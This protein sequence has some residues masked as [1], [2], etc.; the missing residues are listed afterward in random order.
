MRQEE[1]EVEKGKKSIKI[2]IRQY[3][4]IFAMLAIWAYFQ[5]ATGGIFMMPRNLNNLFLQMCYIGV[6]SC[7]MVLIMVSGQ[8]D[9]SAGSVIG[10]T[11][12]I[13]AVLLK[14]FNMN[15][16]LALVLTLAAG[17]L[18]GLW[19]GIWVA[20]VGLPAF[21]VTLS[22]MMLFRGGVLGVTGGSTVQPNDPVFKAIGQGYIPNIGSG[23]INITAIIIGIICFAIYVV[24]MLQKRKNRMKYQFKVDKA[25]V[26]VAK[27][28]GFGIVMGLVFA[29]WASDRGIPIPIIILALVVLT[30]HVISQNT[31][32]G[33]HIFAIGG[34]LDAAKLSGIN[35]KKTITLNFVLMGVL[36]AISGIIYTSRLN[37]AAIAGGTGAETDIIAAAII[38]GTSPAGGKGSI[39]GCIIGAL[40]M[41]SLDNGMSIL[42][43]GSFEKYIVKGLVLLMAVAVDTIT[44]QKAS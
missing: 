9:L 17:A 23:E 20:K 39:F 22:S 16:F 44:S 32:F 8:I 24:L 1:I 3:T 13:M 36:T 30:M 6:C 35:V 15:P 29:I 33:R 34:N 41:A 31:A 40:V 7:G 42:S 11:G 37:S 28:I 2:N 43:M 5:I 12:A 27:I 38:G 25:G 19:Q 21:I 10:F 26:F 14:N 4:M 18:V